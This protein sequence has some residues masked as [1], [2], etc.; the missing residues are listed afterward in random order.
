M[1]QLADLFCHTN[2]IFAKFNMSTSFNTLPFI[3]EGAKTTAWFSNGA[4]DNS[5]LPHKV[6]MDLFLKQ[7]FM[8]D[9]GTNFLGKSVGVET[10]SFGRLMIGSCQ[11]W[12]RFTNSTS[13]LKFINL[14]IDP[15]HKGYALENKALASLYRIMDRYILGVN[16]CE[17]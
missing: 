8:A 2:L 10:V 12:E 9:E 7:I 17:V 11:E 4:R 14:E 3:F 6:W 13:N 1:P 5:V 16:C 15:N